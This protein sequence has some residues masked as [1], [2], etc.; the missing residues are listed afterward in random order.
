MEIVL[1]EQV[2]AL[3][4]KGGPVSGDVAECPALPE[5]APVPEQAW[6][7]TPALSASRGPVETA[8]KDFV[9]AEE[10]FVP[11]ATCELDALP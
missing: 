3:P 4:E 2:A 10:E 1:P 6:W 5:P 7:K 8:Q 9:G 11:G